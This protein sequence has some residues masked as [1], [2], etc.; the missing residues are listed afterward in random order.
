MAQQV[1]NSTNELLQN[2][3]QKQHKTART[4]IIELETNDALFNDLQSCVILET[5]N[6]ESTESVSMIVEGLGFHNVSIR[7][8]SST[9]FLEIFQSEENM[10][11]IDLDFLEI[12]FKVLRKLNWEDLI[13][14]RKVWIECR[15]LPATFWTEGN[16][17]KLCH[18]LGHILQYP[19]QWMKI[20]NIKIH[21]FLLK[22]RYNSMLT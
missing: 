10:E 11:S 16:F 18:N 19:L 12:G 4:N 7:G 1:E 3:L 8:L 9:S 13:P 17:K 22:P 14:P 20:T 15:G 21:L 6:R 2:P 5:V